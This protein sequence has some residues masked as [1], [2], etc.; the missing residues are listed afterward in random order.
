VEATPS[1]SSIMELSLEEVGLRTR[2]EE[3]CQTPTQGQS[4][5][6]FFTVAPS[7][8]FLPNL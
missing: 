5:V 6:F 4:P 8:Y 2:N 3:D 7:Y 1:N